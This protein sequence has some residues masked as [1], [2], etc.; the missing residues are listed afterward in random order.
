MTLSTVEQ[1]VTTGDRAMLLLSLVESIQLLLAYS[2]AFKSEGEFLS[3]L[4]IYVK[5]KNMCELD[6]CAERAG[7]LVWIRNVVYA[8]VRAK[9]IHYTSRPCSVTYL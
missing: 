6:K 2:Y 3:L 1:S 4:H 7:R 8:L 9:L 5:S